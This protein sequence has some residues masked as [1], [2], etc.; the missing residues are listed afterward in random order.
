LSNERLKTVFQN[1]N[2]KVIDTIT[3]NLI[4]VTGYLFQH[5]IISKYH[6]QELISAHTTNGQKAAQLIA[7]LHT[8]DSKQNFVRLRMALKEDAST[9][10]LAKEIDDEY[11]TAGKYTD[12]LD[13][14]NCHRSTPASSD[15]AEGIIM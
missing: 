11:K 9:S 10:W 15:E 7:S 3:P 12:E 8:T 14:A 13:G 4:Q 2:Q 5:N 1:L 6:N